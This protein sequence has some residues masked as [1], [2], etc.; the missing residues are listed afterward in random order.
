MARM[1]GPRRAM[2]RLTQSFRALNTFMVADVN[3]LSP[4]HFQVGI[5]DVCGLPTC[6]EGALVAVMRLSH[7]TPGFTVKPLPT[8]PPG[9]LH[10]IEWK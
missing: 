6:V 3:E 9:G 7:S 1:L 8:E 2:Y 10:D 4:T 5:N